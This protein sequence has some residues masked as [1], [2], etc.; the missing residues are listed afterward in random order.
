MLVHSDAS[1]GR[2]KSGLL[3]S[4]V[5][6]VALVTTRA[7]PDEIGQDLGTPDLKL[8]RSSTWGELVRRCRGME[9]VTKRCGHGGERGRRRD[10]KTGEMRSKKLPWP[11]ATCQRV[12]TDITIS[13]HLVVRKE[14]CVASPIPHVDSAMRSIGHTIDNGHSPAARLL[15]D[16]LNGLLDGREV[17]EQVGRCREAHETSL[18]CEKREKGSHLQPKGK[19]VR[20][21]QRGRQPVFDGE[22]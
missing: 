20:R 4:R 19:G 3:S 7:E 5:V 10:D 17:P 14:H 6:G 13:T 2:I 18:G 8:I 11:E 21:I 9:V 15:F 1:E 22:A 16:G 12:P